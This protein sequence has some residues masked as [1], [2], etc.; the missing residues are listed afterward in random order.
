[1][2][3]R[4]ILDIANNVID[5]SQ[6]MQGRNLSTTVDAMSAK[7]QR[8]AI[9]VPQV[10]P[11]QGVRWAFARG[12]EVEGQ[13]GVLGRR[14]ASAVPP[15]VRTAEPHYLRP[16]LILIARF[17]AY[18][19]RLGSFCSYLTIVEH[20]GRSRSR[21]MASNAHLVVHRPQPM[22]LLGSTIEAPQP[23]QR[24]VSARTCSSVKVSTY[25]LN[26]AA[27]SRSRSTC[28]TSRLALS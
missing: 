21:W 24:A 25:S 26:G 5:D 16:N 22:H 23:R 18:L 13:D 28:A 8:A 17:K 14:A 27:F 6:F 11:K 20:S 19:P 4:Y 9:Q 10:A 2:S 1:M 3:A 7:R 15:F 12:A